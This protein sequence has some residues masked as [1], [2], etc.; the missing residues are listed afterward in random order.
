MYPSSVCS[1]CRTTSAEHAGRTCQEY[2]ETMARRKEDEEEQERQRRLA[3]QRQME[4]LAEAE[5]KRRAEEERRRQEQLFEQKCVQTR[6]DFFTALIGAAKTWGEANWTLSPAIFRPNPG[7]AQL[8][9]AARRFLMQAG[10]QLDL[11]QGFFAWHGTPDG[12][13]DAIA[14]QGFDPRR[15]SGQACGRG[16]YFGIPCATSEGYFPN[17]CWVVD[18]PT[19]WQSSFCL[20]V[21]IMSKNGAAPTCRPIPDDIILPPTH[22]LPIPAVARLIQPPGYQPSGVP[23]VVPLSAG[24]AGGEWCPAPET[25][26]QWKWCD[27]DGY[28]PYMDANNATIESAY[29]RH[30]HHG[31]SAQVNLLLTRLRGDYKNEY[32]VDFS[33]MRQRNQQTGFVRQVTRERKPEVPFSAAQWQYQNESGQWVFL[34]SAIQPLLES[35][36]QRYQAGGAGAG[37]EMDV[38]G[39]PDR[40]SFDLINFKQ[41]NVKTGITKGIRRVVRK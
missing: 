7:L 26:F 36:H 37:I 6:Q 5:R 15:R 21:A 12:A 1:Q 3:E 38:P 35:A 13:V 22:Q 24:M 28:K 33:Q 31:G 40:Y 9:P 2:Q 25:G 16:E 41:T 4:A 29:E 27:D 8:C 17:F 19:D 23:V 39:R 11:S 10:E 34:E 14:W 20:P 30:L 18:N 32:M